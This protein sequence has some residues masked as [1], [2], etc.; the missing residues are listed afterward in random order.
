VATGSTILELKLANCLES[1]Q[2]LVGQSLY[3]PRLPV[4]PT[5]TDT[6]TPTPPDTPTTFE[7]G[8]MDCDGAYF[9]SFSAG[10]YDPEVV[11]SVSVQVY[12]NQ[13][14]FIT[15]IPMELSKDGYSGW[16]SLSDPYNATQ[17]AY[18]QFR[19]VDSFKN[20]TISQ[21]YSERSDSCMPVGQ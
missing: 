20:I 16:D 11:V 4:K 19:A 1:D 8:G 18:Y 13:D 10:A 6:L 9:V 17:I 3:V 2:L 7:I 15:E 14:F 21:R 5:P 12:S